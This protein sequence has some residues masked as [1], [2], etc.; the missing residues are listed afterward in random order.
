[1]EA[2]FNFQGH[3]GRVTLEQTWRPKRELCDAWGKNVRKRGKG[4]DIT[5][6]SREGT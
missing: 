6:G 2:G 1:M 5:R 3:A 4:R